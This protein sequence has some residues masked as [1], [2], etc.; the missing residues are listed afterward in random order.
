MIGREVRA[1][2]REQDLIGDEDVTVDAATPS[3]HPCEL[4]IAIGERIR[5]LT[6]LDTVDVINGSVATV[7][8][9][10]SGGT[11]AED[12]RHAAR[13]IEALVD[14]RPIAFDT[15]ELVDRRGRI[16][17]G[18]AYAST[19]YGPQGMTVDNAAVLV[20][21]E[22]DRH[23]IY[24]AASWARET[25]TLMM[26][27]RAVDRPMDGGNDDGPLLSRTA[28]DEAE[29]RARL[30]QARIKETTIDIVAP[31]TVG[32]TP[33]HD[34]HR[35]LTARPPSRKTAHVREAGHEL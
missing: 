14:H 35:A 18:W 19:L 13:R 2:L 16:R 3:G 26:D 12:T 28:T 15:R 27:R 29:P 6:R 21:P 9:V 32:A 17:L 7:T 1:R 23:D 10:M 33:K 22:F 11:D 34:R 4:P 24:V 30:S 31:P 5:F 20:T 8:H 25:T